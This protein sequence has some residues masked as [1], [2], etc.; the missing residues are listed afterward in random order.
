VGTGPGWLG[1]SVAAKRKIV[2]G[3]ASQFKKSTAS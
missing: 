1:P 2:R 3:A